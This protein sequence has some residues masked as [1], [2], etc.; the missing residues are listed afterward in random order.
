MVTANLTEERE[1]L[2]NLRSFGILDTFSETDYDDITKMA[3]IICEAPIALISFVDQDRQWFKSARGLSVSETAR[4]HSFCSHAIQTKHQPFI[5][6]DSR[7]D[8]RFKDNPLVTGDPNIVFYAGIPLVSDDGFGLGTVCII[9]TKPRVL[10]SDQLDALQILSRQTITLLNLRKTNKRLAQATKELEHKNFELDVYGKGLEKQLEEH[11]YDR[12]NEIE[13]QNAEL[14]RMNEELRSFSYI[15]SHDLQEPLRKIQIFCSL[16]LEKEFGSLSGQ[17]KEYFTKIQ[18]STSRMSALIRDLL[19]YS[20]TT[21]TDRVFESISLQKVVHE[22]VADLNEEIQQKGAVV[23]CNCE[24]EISVIPFQFTQL[25]Y[26]LFSNALKFS[27]EDVSPV[28]NI[29]TGY[30]TGR[31]FG[32]AELQKNMGYTRISVSDNGMGF[33]NKYSEKIFNLFQ[34]LHSTDVQMGTGIGLTIVKKIVSNHNGYIKANGAE[35][36]GANFNIYLPDNL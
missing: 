4:E 10:T 12:L 33:N 9:D 32:I 25:L 6:E 36:S 26:N 28:I 14:E 2:L 34:R 29:T 24:A 5:V 3:S 23:V 22:V 17:G 16:I 7:I 1:R 13:A 30:N 21:S 27:R 8:I 11:M 18:K 31:E 35:F 20:R 19:A 15:S